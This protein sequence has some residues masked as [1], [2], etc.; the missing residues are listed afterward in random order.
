MEKTDAVVATV[1]DKFGTKALEYLEAFEKL[2]VQH[3]PDVVETG[4]RVVQ[5][6]AIQSLIMPAA[7]FVAGSFV[8]YQGR[9]LWN[10]GKEIHQHDRD[11]VRDPRDR[12]NFYL[13]GACLG[14]IGGFIILFAATEL[15]NIWK[16]IALFE[17]KL[18]LAYR[19]FEKLL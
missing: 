8:C 18:Y 6:N 12:D 4:L 1:A 16:W 2:A 19:I 7:F 10:I 17:P 5:I 14:V 13:P 3:T 15:F 11:N 9:R